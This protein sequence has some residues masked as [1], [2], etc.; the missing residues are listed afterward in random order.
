MNINV[1]VKYEFDDKPA[2]AT[3][4]NPSSINKQL[5]E[6]TS[7]LPTSLENKETDADLQDQS[8][9]GFSLQPQARERYAE[10]NKPEQPNQ[11]IGTNKFGDQFNQF[12]DKLGLDQD[13]IFEEIYGES[14][15][16]SLET[17]YFNPLLQVKMT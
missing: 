4:L 9:T 12:R 6:E 2:F 7:S 8:K 11:D 14:K 5:E 16:K 17:T 10:A 1:N 13:D 3:G 15:K